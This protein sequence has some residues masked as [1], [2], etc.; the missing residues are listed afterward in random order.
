M[1][2][3][4][5]DIQEEINNV[6]SI[7]FQHNTCIRKYIRHPHKN[8]HKSL[9]SVSDTDQTVTGKLLASM[10]APINIRSNDKS[11]TNS[12]TLNQT[13]KIKFIPATWWELPH[14]LSRISRL[15][16]KCTQPLA[17]LDL[18]KRWEMT[19]SLFM[20]QISFAVTTINMT[21]LST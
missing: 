14:N 18:D 11:S 1:T 2:T 6:L 4:I 9:I 20:S 17:I 15:K 10:K 3:A 12:I 7:P 19:S 21:T 8:L 16:H 5:Q 13:I